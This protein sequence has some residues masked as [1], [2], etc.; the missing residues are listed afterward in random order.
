M[1]RILCIVCNIAAMVLATAGI[2]AL[3]FLAAPL[4]AQHDEGRGLQLP[5]RYGCHTM[6]AAVALVEAGPGRG[7][8]T[9]ELLRNGIC[10]DMGDWFLVTPH[11]IVGEVVWAGDGQDDMMYI[12]ETAD[13]FGSLAFGWVLVGMYPA[14][15]K[16]MGSGGHQ[17]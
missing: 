9:A 2:L 7:R 13:Q 6:E 8:L 4:A 17:I 15:K 12:V 5:M 14:L 10:F 3:L 1:N 11:Q 16:L